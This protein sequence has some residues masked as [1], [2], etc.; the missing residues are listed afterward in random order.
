[1]IHSLTYQPRGVE[2]DDVLRRWRRQ[3][4]AL[5][6]LSALL[7]AALLGRAFDEFGGAVPLGYDT[8]YAAAAKAE[9]LHP[10][11]SV[12][13][14]S[15]PAVFAAWGVRVAI[16]ILPR[17]TDRTAA[18]FCLGLNAAMVLAYLAGIAL[19]FY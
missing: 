10:V 6:L 15:V 5:T 12:V 11:A 3:L 7:G 14:L 2:N 9:G 1:M 4:A 17:T 19:L 13:L 16:R 8:D 18:Q